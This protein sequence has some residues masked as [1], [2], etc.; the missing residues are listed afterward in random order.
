MRVVSKSLF[1]AAFAMLAPAVAQAGLVV[2]QNYDPSF[3]AEDGFA[4]SPTSNFQRAETFTVGIAGTLAEVGI[5]TSSASTTFS[6]IDILSTSGGTPTLTVLASG[7]YVSTNSDGLAMFD[8]SLPVT[9]GEVLGL[10]PFVSSAGNW[11][12]RSPG[13]YVGGQ[14][15]FM[16]Q[17]IFGDQFLSDGNS[18]GFVTYV[19]TGGSSSVPEPASFALLGGGLALL[20]GLRA[21]GKP[22]Y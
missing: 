9:V 8:V 3:N 17:S 7:T 6:G 20:F 22:S 12:T 5:Y 21:R 4:S 1:F 2:D 13:T 18:D 11:E 15:F 14:D 10:E 16:N 19:N